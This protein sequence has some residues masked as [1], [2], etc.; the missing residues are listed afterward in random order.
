MKTGE[1]V[2]LENEYVK[3]E[4]EIR[5]VVNGV[6]RLERELGCGV[7]DEPVVFGSMKEKILELSLLSPTQVRLYAVV[8]AEVP[9][10]IAKV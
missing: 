6:S 8:F 3:F 9:Q 1:E 10:L 5:A 7:S 4:R 2:M